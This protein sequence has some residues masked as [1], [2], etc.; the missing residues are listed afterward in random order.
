MI[1]KRRGLSMTQ[2]QT[3]KIGIFKC[4][5]IASSLIFEL[6]LDELADRQDIK[7]RTITTGS[8]MSVE[9]IEEALPKLFEF[10]PDLL[11]LISPNTSLPGPT[12]AR[13]KLSNTRIPSIIISDAPAKRAKSDIEKQGLGY[14]IILGDPLIGAR[15]EFLDPTEMAIFNSN[16]IKVLAITGVYR[17][18]H[19][20]IDKLITAIKKSSPP[21]LPKLVID[22]STIRDTSNFTNPYAKAKAMAAYELLEKIAEINF[23]ACFTE[24]DCKK[25]VPLVAS[26]H[27]IAQAAAKLAEEAREIEKTSDTVLRNPHAKDG[28]IKTKTRLMSPPTAEE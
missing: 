8:K 23:Q 9:D 2:Q 10:A 14:I 5:N 4:G 22:I 6:L 12:K 17:I 27:E 16:I 25:Y 15:R 11:I 7:T 1:Y 18:I 20:E 3:T 13:E 26:A 24:K 21:V 19:Q 28:R